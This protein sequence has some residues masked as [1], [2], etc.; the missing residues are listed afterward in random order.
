MLK[1]QSVVKVGDGPDPSN[2]A[3]AGETILDARNFFMINGPWAH[4]KHSSR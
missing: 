1:L 3:D 2:P 4:L